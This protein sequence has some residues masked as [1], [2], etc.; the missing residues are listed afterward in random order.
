MKIILEGFNEKL[1]VKVLA[2]LLIKYDSVI[3]I[4]SAGFVEIFAVE[5]LVKFVMLASEVGWT[6]GR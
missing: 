5:L 2:I 6:V 3:L 1:D 4:L